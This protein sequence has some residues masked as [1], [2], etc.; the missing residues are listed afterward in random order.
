[1][2]VLQL[3][4]A[5][6]PVNLGG[7]EVV[8]KLLAEGL[9]EN[10]VLCDVLGVNSSYNFVV[11][12]G[13]FGGKIFRTKLIKKMFSTLL[14]LQLISKLYE[15]RNEYQII[16]IHSPDPM[17][18]LALFIVKPK[19]K[20]VLHWHSDILK[21]RI[22]LVFYFPILKW[23]LKR[24]DLILATSPNYIE[25]SY[26]LRKFKKKVEVLAIGIDNTIPNKIDKSIKNKF[27]GKKIIFSL[28]RF[29]YYKGYEYLVKSMEFLSDDYILILAGDGSERK[30]IE[31]II[32]EKKLN[33]KIN[34]VGKIDDYLKDQFF[35]ICDVFVLSSIL[36]TEAFA[37]VQVEALSYGK[38]IISTKIEGSG[39]DWV[40]NDGET[41]YI[42]PI[43][44][45]IAISN[46]IVKLLSN[47]DL[48]KFKLNS[49]IRFNKKFTKKVM[50]DNLLKKYTRLANSN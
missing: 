45:P 48:S 7:V 30:K 26:L 5:Y 22:L 31:K 34:L 19:C 28:G 18:A 43:K 21:Q 40:N 24:S 12:E 13:K 35:Q 20:I 29:S 36:K 49:K 41:G 16:H 14:S 6:P 8:I 11:E 23:L 47:E 3:G 25:G 10:N 39:V 9:N 37:I 27:E 17:A 4:K 44:D 46:S 33:N 15:L 32:T 2:K 50:I 38:P 1:M 42:V